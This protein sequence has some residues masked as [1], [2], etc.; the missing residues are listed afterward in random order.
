LAYAF[1]SYFFIIIA[2]GHIWKFITLAYIP[3]TIA[4]IILAYRGKYLKG[5]ILAAFFG[6]LQ[7]HANHIQMSYYSFLFIIP[8]V[9]GYLLHAIQ[10][11]ELKK[12]GKSTLA[13]VVAAIFAVAAN[14]PSIYNTYEYSKETMRGKSSLASEVTTQDNGDGGLSLA[15]ITQ[16]SYGIGESWTLL[17][18]DTK[19]GATGYISKDKEAMEEVI[20]SLRQYVGQMNHY[21][22]DQPFTAGPVYAGAIIMFLFF[23][24]GLGLI[25]LSGGN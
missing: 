12:F 25:I 19:G 1:S 15:Y 7:I 16:W 22:G 2:A 13:L 14:L 21:W 11:K 5:A 20:P 9:I 23:I 6:M 4:G 17:I 8:L 18:P 10:H 24:A 3:P